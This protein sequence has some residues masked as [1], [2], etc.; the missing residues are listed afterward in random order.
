MP[1]TLEALKEGDLVYWGYTA[2]KIRHAGL[3]LGQERFIHTSVRENKPYLRISK[4]SDPEWNGSATATYPYRTFRT[5]R[6]E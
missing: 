2:E 4:I 3:Y 5:L 1:T 6:T